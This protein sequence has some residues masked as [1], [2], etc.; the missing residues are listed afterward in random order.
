MAKQHSEKSRWPSKY[1]PKGWVTASQYL[2]ELVCEAKARKEEKLLPIKFWELKEW[3][4]Y[5]AF[6]SVLANR[7]MKE[8]SEL[9]L[10]KAIKDPKCFYVY[11]LGAPQI[12][13]IAARYE[14]E[15]SNAPEPKV[16][17]KFDDLVMNPRP[18]IQT[19]HSIV[20]KLS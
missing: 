18:S 10:I 4:K 6:Q 9:A 13:K 3:A 7:L 15:L 19:G 5:F 1:S 14:L 12:K 11:S 20:G 8:F 16:E 2:V 17:D